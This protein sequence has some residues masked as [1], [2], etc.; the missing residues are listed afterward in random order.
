VRTEGVFRGQWAFPGG[1]LEPGETAW[2]AARRELAEE[3]GI[4]CRGQAEWSLR[5]TVAADGNVWDIA[6]FGVIVEE[7]EP[8]TDPGAA[9]LSWH[10]PLGPLA[11]GTEAVLDHL[12]AWAG[13]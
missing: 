3:T 8:P 2:A 13:P 6:N 1:R 11:L 4:S 7:S 10:E 12:R 5:V 9:W